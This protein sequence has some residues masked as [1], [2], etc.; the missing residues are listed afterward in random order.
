MASKFDYNKARATAKK[1]ITKFGVDGSVYTNGTDGGENALG[2]P[3][4][5]EPGMLIEGV[6]TPLLPY[7]T[8]TQL[9]QYEKEN[10]IA[11]DMFAFFHS[12]TLVEV[13]MLLDASGS[14]WRVQSIKS[15]SSNAGVNVFQKLMLRK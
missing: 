12:D 1:L 2:Q 4:P 5:S 15:L 6:I 11:G 10:M 14:T 3:L 13:N 7:S 8:S 9:T